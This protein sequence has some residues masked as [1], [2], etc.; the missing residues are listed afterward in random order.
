MA[1]FGGGGQQ[2][3]K[4]DINQ[5]WDLLGIEMNPDR[6]ILLGVVPE[7]PDP[8]Y[9]WIVPATTIGL[10][11]RRVLAFVEK[12]DRDLAEELMSRG[13]LLNTFVVAAS[14]RTLLFL[15]RLCLP[16]LLAACRGES[17]EAFE[18]GAPARACPRRAAC[19]APGTR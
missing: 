4:G 10:G 3:P 2:L 13:A 17:G 6:V 14:V 15:F 5:L 1:M 7:F 16:D 8:E 19:F 11:T 12:P 9:G 18:G